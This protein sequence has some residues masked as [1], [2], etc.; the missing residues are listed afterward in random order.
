MENNSKIDDLTL[1]ESYNLLEIDSNA[2]FE[3]IKKKYKKMLLKYHPDKNIN[4]TN[5]HSHDQFIKIQQAF[6][7]ISSHKIQNKTADN[8]NE[9]I[10][11]NDINDVND[12]INSNDV[13]GILKYYVKN[14]H[15]EINVFYENVIKLFRI[16]EHELK[17]D[18][19]TFNIDNIAK[20]ISIK[21]ILTADE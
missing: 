4:N 1:E 5:I 17:N 11:I 8:S 3:E 21:N 9:D 13:Y 19:N 2:S 14:K 12:L 7:I 20:K 6:N 10:D 16:N 18:V 15:P